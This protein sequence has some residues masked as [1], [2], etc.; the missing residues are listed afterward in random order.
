MQGHGVHLIDK[1]YSATTSGINLDNNP[2]SD[3]KIVTKHSP[4]QLQ[5]IQ[6]EKGVEEIV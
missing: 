1:I 3:I 4:G 2:H 6:P 5:A